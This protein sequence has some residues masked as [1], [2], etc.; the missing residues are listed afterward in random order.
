MST[1]APER[2]T[3][4]PCS[5]CRAMVIGLN[6]CPHCGGNWIGTRVEYIRADLVRQEAEQDNKDLGEAGKLHRG[7]PR[8]EIETH[9]TLNDN[10]SM[11]IEEHLRMIETWAQ[12]PKPNQEAFMAQR[13]IPFHVAAVRD[14]LAGVVLVAEAARNFMWDGENW[15][16]YEESKR[17]N[18]VAWPPEFLLL[19]QAVEVEYG[20]IPLDGPCK[21]CGAKT[22]ATHDSDCPENPVYDSL[23]QPSTSDVLASPDRGISARLETESAPPLTRDTED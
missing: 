18:S 11:S 14:S 15:E 20:A 12:P 19:A 5:K 1:E 4:G 17:S 2:I 23:G 6:A 8:A 21:L 13:A 9:S 10:E 16:A 22:V 3:A 7:V